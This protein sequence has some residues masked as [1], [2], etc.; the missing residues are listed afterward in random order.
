MTKFQAFM[1]AHQFSQYRL[2]K[3]TGISKSQISEWQR[4]KH[5][6]SLASARHLAIT[7]RM[8]IH[9]IKSQL[10][11]RESYQNARTPEGQFV[12]RSKQNSRAIAETNDATRTD[13]TY[14]LTCGRILGQAA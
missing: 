4:G 13:A 7:L 3:L 5:R 11:L 1:D 2:H 6:P 14:C 10:E 12:A 8:S 9:D